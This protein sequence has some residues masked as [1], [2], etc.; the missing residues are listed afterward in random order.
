MHVLLVHN[1]DAGDGHFDRES[2]LRLIRDAGHTVAYTVADDDWKAAMVDR[3]EVIV[4][5]GGDGTVHKVARTAAHRGIPITVI[6][7][8]TANNIAGEL[9]LSARAIPDIIAGWADAVRRPFDLGLAGPG[10][11]RAFLESAGVGL[12]AVTIA[13]IAHGNAA[14]V[15]ELNEA[16]ERLEAA[17]E[18][19]RDTLTRLEPIHVD[20]RLDGRV[21]SGRFLLVEVLNFGGAGANL[22]LAHRADPADGL[23]DIVV[24]DETG[25]QELWD[26]LPIYRTDPARAPRLPAYQARHVELSCRPCALHLDDKLRRVDATRRGPIELTVDPQALTFLV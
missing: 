11:A 22:R 19:L 21:V 20:M 25:R 26:N 3:V 18:V 1:P 12:L 17:I 2:L 7:L 5:A 13:R 15:D 4:A 10:K 9:G 8:G 14:Y 23:F 6:P 16:E 24:V